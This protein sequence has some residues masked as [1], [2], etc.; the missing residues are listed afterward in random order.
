MFS[1]CG[2]VVHAL[3][4]PLWSDH[5]E[6]DELYGHM[7]HLHTFSGI[8]VNVCLDVLAFRLVFRHDRT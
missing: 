6:E 7:K 8:A 5:T 2:F 4:F 3:A 1:Q